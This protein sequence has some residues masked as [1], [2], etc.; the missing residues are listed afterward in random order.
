MLCLSIVSS[1]KQYM[2][3]AAMTSGTQSESRVQSAPN[4]GHAVLRPQAELERQELALHYK[5]GR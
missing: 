3:P 5:L 1:Q 4:P 2:C